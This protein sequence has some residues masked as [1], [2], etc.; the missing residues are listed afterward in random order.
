VFLSFGVGTPAP[1]YGPDEPFLPVTGSLG[2]RCDAVRVRAR[3]PVPNPAP[4]VSITAIPDGE[5]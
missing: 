1:V 4:L 5:L 3:A 2:R